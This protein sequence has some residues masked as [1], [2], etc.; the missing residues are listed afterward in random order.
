MGGGRGDG[1]RGHFYCMLCFLGMKSG[2]GQYE[3]AILAKP[4]QQR[5]FRAGGV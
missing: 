2:T 4:E 5:G 3:V 1:Q